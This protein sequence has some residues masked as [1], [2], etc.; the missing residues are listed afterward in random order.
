MGLEDGRIDNE[1]DQSLQREDTTSAI[2]AERRRLA[3]QLQAN[4]IEPLNLLLSQAHVYEQTMSQNP[5]AR[6]AISVLSSLAR[7][8]LQ[9]VRDLEANLHPAL[10]E[11]LGLEAALETLASQY[12]R[13]HSVQI[14]LALARL[15]ERL[16]HPIELTLFRAAQDALEQ[17]VTRARASHVFIRLENR[18][19]WFTCSFADN[20]LPSDAA[21][22][23]THIRQRIEALGGLCETQ[24]GEHGGFEMHI[25]F[26]LKPPIELTLR[27]QQVIK[28]LAQGLSNKQI[29]GTLQVSA[30][31]VNFHLDNIYSKLGV[32]TRTEA[33][34]YALR[35]GWVTG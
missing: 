16:P 35:Q 5:Q 8:L 17:G 10:L 14:T 25:R 23:F 13:T 18:E 7:G 22:P 34:I 2:E 6:M 11:T 12:M 15:A 9:Q 26:L 4:I 28:L 1:I 3:A 19:E 21:D 29:A 31:T 20:R 33:A 24:S 32:S 27:E 30:R